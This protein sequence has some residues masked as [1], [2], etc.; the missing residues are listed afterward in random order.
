[1]K[2]YMVSCIAQCIAKVQTEETTSLRT[3]VST[4]RL[5]VDVSSHRYMYYTYGMHIYN[6]TW[7]HLHP[8]TRVTT[9]RSLP[10]VCVCVRE[11]MCSLTACFLA[12]G[13]AMWVCCWCRPGR[14]RCG[15]WTEG[16][17]WCGWRAVFWCVMFTWSPADR[18]V[19]AAWLGHVWCG[20]LKSVRCVVYVYCVNVCRMSVWVR[21]VWWYGWEAGNVG[22]VRCRVW[23]LLELVCN[24]VF[25]LF[26][27]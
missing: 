18:S 21:R 20:G 27:L 5:F 12:R 8:W 23:F 24:A 10:A 2:M 22:W 19:A 13:L 6:M 26:Y 25:S 9:H 11:Y 3:N 14:S 17:A 15:L 7:T 16:H 1:M 4:P